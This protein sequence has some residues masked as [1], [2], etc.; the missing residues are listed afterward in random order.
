[1]IKKL[2]IP[3][4]IVF[5][6]SFSDLSSSHNASRYFPFLEKPEDYI[7]HKESF[8]EPSL[9]I[10]SAGSAFKSGD[11]SQGIAELW[12]K[13]DLKDVIEAIDA[14]TVG[15]YNPFSGEPGYVDWN[16]KEI[17]FNIDGKVKSRGLILALNQNIAKSDF[18]V[19]VFLP[20]MHVNNS[21]FFTFDADSSHNDVQNLT[22]QELEMLD[23]VRRSVHRDL[24]LKGRD[25]TKSGV[26]DLDLYISWQRYF[27]HAM[28]MK[29]VSLDF[30]GGALVPIGAQ[31]D[32]DYPSS[33]PFMGNGHWGAYLDMVGE[34]ELK[35][36][37]KFGLMG[38]YIYQFSD[39]A[40][41]RISY[42]R[43][44]GIFSP[45]YGRIKVSPGGTLKFGANFTLENLTDGLN[46]QLRY[47]ILNHF[48][49]KWYDKRSNKSVSSYLE[50]FK[51]GYD[52]VLEEKERL[53]RWSSHYISMQVEYDSKEAMKDWLFQP[54]LFATYD[55][56]FRG[57]RSAKTNQFTVGV[58][59]HF[60]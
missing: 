58:Q 50:T 22:P 10:T 40:D 27:D 5:I 31:S 47:T 39:T 4:A 3:C 34:F 1:M 18:H 11:G 16:T 53:S 56:P 60:W 13:Y 26:G 52:D 24:G 8:V 32:K 17:K 59:L 29:S 44:P 25:W 42:F 19:G 30:R 21:L 2:L 20:V 23:R 38:G 57:K 37:W 28:N 35:Q 33:T 55:Y 48:T 41:R 49:D 43:E 46:L 7:T 9:F 36:N 51:N 15:T 12:G 14:T 6:S 45:L 54:K